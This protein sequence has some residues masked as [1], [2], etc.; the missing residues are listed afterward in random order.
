MR[1]SPVRRY[2][3]NVYQ[4][5]F[6]HFSSPVV[7]EQQKGFHEDTSVKKKDRLTSRTEDCYVL[8]AGVSA[9]I[10]SN[11]FLVSLGIAFTNNV[12][13]AEFIVI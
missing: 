8:S 5:L 4:A 12:S 10:E 7:M 9:G 3:Y 2:I 13:D 1:P 6:E 11:A